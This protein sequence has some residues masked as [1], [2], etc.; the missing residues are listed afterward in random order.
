M[1]VESAGA[2]ATFQLGSKGFV[3]LQN[4]EHVPQHFKH[5]AVGARTNRRRA[6]VVAHAGH[7]TEQVARPQFGDGIVVRQVDRRIDRNKRPVAFL[8]AL[9]LLPRTE[10]ALQLLEKAF[11]I[12]LRSDVLPSRMWKAVEPNSPSRQMISPER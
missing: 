11:A 12:A 9:V 2:V 4:I 7:L 6:R 8:V 10:Y 5:H 1:R 3:P